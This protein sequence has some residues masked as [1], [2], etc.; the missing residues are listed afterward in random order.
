MQVVQTLA[1]FVMSTHVKDMGVEE[2][3]DGFL[4]SEV[5]LGE[6]ILDLPKII[7]ICRAANPDVTF[8]LEM[9]TRDPLEIPCLRPDYWATLDEVKGTEVAGT[10]RMVR[11]KKPKEQLPKV[12]QLSPEERLAVEE[13]N[14][15]TSLT[16]SQKTL[17]MA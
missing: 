5:P 2:Y 1:P 13:K 11:E 12:A 17:G 8:N 16:Y 3:G 15:L 14:I 7:Q 4:L 6:G 9:I 10:L